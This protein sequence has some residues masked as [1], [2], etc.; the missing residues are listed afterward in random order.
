LPAAFG[1]NLLF[2]LPNGNPAP[3]PKFDYTLHWFERL[4]LHAAGLLAS[5]KSTIP[6]GDDYQISG[7]IYVSVLQ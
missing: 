1:F 7:K 3:G 6:T 2:Y 4:T 5:G